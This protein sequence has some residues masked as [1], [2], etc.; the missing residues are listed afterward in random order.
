MGWPPPA[1]DGLGPHPHALETPI[2]NMQDQKSRE[3]KESGRR[4]HDKPPLRDAVAHANERY[5]RRV[6]AERRQH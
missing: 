4:R 6:A 3:S 2:E 1:H 5:Q